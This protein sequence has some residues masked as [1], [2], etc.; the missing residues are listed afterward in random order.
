MTPDA[1]LGN[2]RDPK[3][4]CDSNGEIRLR[5]ILDRFSVE[6]FVNDGEVKINVATYDLLSEK[7]H[8]TV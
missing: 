3:I 1:I 7:G 4:W 6:A 8:E 2:Y 5:L